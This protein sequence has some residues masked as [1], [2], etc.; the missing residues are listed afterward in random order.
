MTLEDSDAVNEELKDDMRMQFKEIGLVRIP[1][2]S[3]DVSQLLV[4]HRL[5]IILRL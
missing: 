3:R 2:I 5:I 4:K 1:S